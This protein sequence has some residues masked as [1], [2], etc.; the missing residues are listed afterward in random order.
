MFVNQDVL[1]SQISKNVIRPD[2]S[3]LPLSS[4]R[5][6]R[7]SRGETVAPRPHQEPTEMKN[8]FFVEEDMTYKFLPIDP[9]MLGKILSHMPEFIK[10]RYQNWQRREIFADANK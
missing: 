5:G 9:R 6:Q 2:E 3:Y 10:W 1:L 8:S 7:R 4:L